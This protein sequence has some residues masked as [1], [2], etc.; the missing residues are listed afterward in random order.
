MRSRSRV[1]LVNKVVSSL[2]LIV[3]VLK[4]KCP[5]LTTTGDPQSCPLHAGPSRCVQLCGG[6]VSSGDTFV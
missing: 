6:G 3:C 5:P 1:I 4:W 2:T